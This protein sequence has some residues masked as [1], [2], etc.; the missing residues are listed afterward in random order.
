MWLQPLFQTFF[1]WIQYAQRSV[2]WW[3]SRV[4]L[5]FGDKYSLCTFYRLGEIP[6]RSQLLYILRSIRGQERAITSSRGGK[7]A[8]ILLPQIQEG[9][10][11]KEVTDERESPGASKTN[12]GSE[13]GSLPSASDLTD[14]GDLE[15]LKEVCKKKRMTQIVDLG[16]SNF[17]EVAWKIFFNGISIYSICITVNLRCYWPDT[18]PYMCV[19]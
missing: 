18:R 15:E 2:D 19:L 7:P 5:T 16:T 9:G 4:T 12:S 10:L 14:F 13:L 11:S 3:H 17:S 6:S 8:I 1:S